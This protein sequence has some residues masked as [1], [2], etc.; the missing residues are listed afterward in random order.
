MGFLGGLIAGLALWV[1]MIVGTGSMCALPW[2]SWGCNDALA[3][4]GNAAETL[5]IWDLVLLVALPSVGAVS[6]ARKLGAKRP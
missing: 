4:G 3:A 6:G 5:G 2:V 1:V